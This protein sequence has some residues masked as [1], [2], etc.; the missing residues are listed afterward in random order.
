MVQ[1]LGRIV[2]RCRLPALGLRLPRLDGGLLRRLSG[3]AEW[4][5]APYAPGMVPGAALLIVKAGMPGFEHLPIVGH[6]NGIRPLG[7]VLR[8][9]GKLWIKWPGGVERV[10]IG[11]RVQVLRTSEFAGGIAPLA[12]SFADVYPIVKRFAAVHFPHQALRLLDP[13]TANRVYRAPVILLNLHFS[14]SM[15]CLIKRQP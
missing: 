6:P 2:D 12:Q 9:F 10:A 4:R 14:I 11:L 1:S 5:M 15:I 13:C 7:F 3:F 8:D